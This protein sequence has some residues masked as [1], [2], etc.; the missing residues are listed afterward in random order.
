M[1]KIA[2]NYPCCG[3]EWTDKIG[4]SKI[5]DFGLGISKNGTNIIWT[6]IKDTYFFKVAGP[7]L[8]NWVCH[9]HLKFRIKMGVASLIFELRPYNFG[10]MFIF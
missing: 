3:L 1:G 4:F 6:S 8:K 2:Q 5:T 10:K 9:T 7:W